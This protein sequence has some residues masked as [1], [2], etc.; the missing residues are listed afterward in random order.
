MTT[1]TQTADLLKGIAAVLMIQVH[2]IELFATPEIYSSNIGKFLLFLGGPPVAPIF[3]FFLGY[4]IAESKKSTTQL[5]IRG[6]KILAL[7]FLLNIALNLNLIISVTRGR[8]DIDLKPYLFGVDVLPQ[9]GL[10]IIII[11]LLKP[12]FDKS[13]IFPVILLLGIAFLGDFFL[14]T[15]PEQPVLKYIGAFFYGDAWW[16]YFPLLP[17]FAYALAGIVFCKLSKRYGLNFLNGNKTKLIA[18]LLSILFLFFTI[19]YAITISST[20]ENYYHHGSLFFL[21]TITFLAFYTFFINEITKMVSANPLFT[22]LQW[23]GKNITVIYIFQWIIIGNCAT[24]IYKTVLSPWYL[25]L[26]F[27]VVL[28]LSSYLCFLWLKIKTTLSKHA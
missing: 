24:E 7:G 15:I 6:L 17:W 8:F 25:C 4:F 20:L 1:R 28:T 3:I 19:H 10:A 22:Y 12:L 13:A 26:S 27:V 11:A 9:A 5:I 23:L 2:L 16:A 14:A 18:L 21:W